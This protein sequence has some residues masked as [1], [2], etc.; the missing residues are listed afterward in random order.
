ML[1]GTGLCLTLQRDVSRGCSKSEGKGMLPFCIR[2]CAIVCQAAGH[3][4]A[5]GSCKMESDVCLPT[6]T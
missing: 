5:E 6:A 1:L 4:D 3:I 2:R